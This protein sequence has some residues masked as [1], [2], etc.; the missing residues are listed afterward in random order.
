EHREA[1]SEGLSVREDVLR[2]AVVLAQ[3]Q[4]FARDAEIVH[5]AAEERDVCARPSI[6]GLVAVPHGEDIARIERERA[7]DGVLDRIEILEL[8]DQDRVP[9]RAQCFGGRRM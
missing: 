9:S 7:D 2:G 3:P 5:E 4:R 1:I 8:V 6:Y